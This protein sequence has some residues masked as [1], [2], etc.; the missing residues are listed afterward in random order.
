[1][2]AV[3]KGVHALSVPSPEI[4]FWRVN[5]PSNFSPG[6]VPETP[7][8]WSILCE[9]SLAPA[10]H[11]QH[12]PASI[13]ATLRQ[14]G[15][16][17]PLTEVVSS[18]TNEFEHG[19][20]VPFAGRDKLLNRVQAKFEQLHIYSRGRFGGWRYEVSNQDHAFMQGVEVIERLLTGKPEYTYRQTWQSQTDP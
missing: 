17:P 4:P 7:A 11:V 12:D 1:M 8:A 16:I 10:S 20:P 13:E 9:V 6:N 19:Y 18:F 15:F 5:I 3:L 2:P 14:M